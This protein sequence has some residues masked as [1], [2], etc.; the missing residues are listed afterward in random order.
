MLHAPLSRRVFT[1]G[2]SDSHV[3]I[4]PGVAA[5]SDRPLS[6]PSFYKEW[7]ELHMQKA[8]E[9]V[10]REGMAI[11]EAAL[12]FGVPKSTLGD[13]IS[14]RVIVG[15]TSGPKPYLNVEEE[16]E[17]VKFLLRSSAIGY[18]KSRQEVLAIVT[19]MLERKGMHANVTSGWW[20]SFCRRHPNLTLRAPASLSKARHNASDPEIV[21]RY[22]D[23]LEQTM[24][25]NELLDKP[26]QI[27]NVDESGMPLNPKP[28]K[29]VFLSG[30][31]RILSLQ[32]LAI[33]HK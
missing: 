1:S 32:R 15:S 4:N 24:I 18:P 14:G 17:L 16:E 25:D 12:R 6:R 2:S 9:A 11:R 21:R 7:D 23:L 30:A 29:G 27:L 3:R 26:G 19:R 8:I 28:V 10:T 22:F 5:A 33:S 31:L 13:R 20:Q